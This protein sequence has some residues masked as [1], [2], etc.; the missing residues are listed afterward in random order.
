LQLELQGKETK[1]V[2]VA[3]V[4]QEVGEVQVEQVQTLQQHSLALVE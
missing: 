3:L 2:L 4:Q 1:A